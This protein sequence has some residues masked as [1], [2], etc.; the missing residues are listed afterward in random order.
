MT[1]LYL[2]FSFVTFC[3]MYAYHLLL[4]L[5]NLLSIS[6]GAHMESFYNLSGKQFPACTF[7]KPSGG[8]AWSEV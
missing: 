8:W 3:V 1:V 5:K 7:E 6:Y 2:A 4:I